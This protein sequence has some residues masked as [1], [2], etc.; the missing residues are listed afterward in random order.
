M[1]TA[2]AE[3]PVYHPAIGTAWRHDNGNLY[4]VVGLSNQHSTDQ[5]KYP[6]TVHYMGGNGRQWS[7][8][9]SDWHRSMHPA[10]Q[11][12]RFKPSE[13]V[14]DDIEHLYWA[15][16]RICKDNADLGIGQNFALAMLTLVNIYR[17]IGRLPND[18]KP[19]YAL[20]PA[21][22]SHAA[23]VFS[24]PRGL[25]VSERDHFKMCARELINCWFSLE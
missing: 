12:L 2:V 7:R 4:W 1:N 3:T 19:V 16:D 6:A 8:P 10:D 13:L 20:R 11:S 15:F 5:N 18:V 14:E 23:L 22:A 17:S 24:T 25:G 21:R 9:L